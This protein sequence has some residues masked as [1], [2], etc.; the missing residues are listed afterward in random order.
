[1]DQ[2]LKVKNKILKYFVE[3][4]HETLSALDVGKFF[5]KNTKILIIMTIMK[6]IKIHLKKVK[7]TSNKL[8]NYIHRRYNQERVSK[9]HQ[10]YINSI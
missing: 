3:K 5:L 2:D 6:L 4:I 7:T 10:K 9:I 8:E 1:M